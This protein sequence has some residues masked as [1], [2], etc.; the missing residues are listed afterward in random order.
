MRAEAKTRTEMAPRA[1]KA[2][3]FGRGS[4]N[5]LWTKLVASETAIWAGGVFSGAFIY[6]WLWVDCR[7]QHN[8]VSPVFLK[9]WTF[10]TERL[11]HPG[12]PVDYVSGWLW[13]GYRFP[14]IGSLTTA[15][16]T[17]LIF[18]AANRLISTCGWR[19]SRPLA[20]GA[21][22][23]FIDAQNL[24]YTDWLTTALALG[25]SLFLAAAYSFL[26]V[27]PLGRCLGFVLAFT[28]LYLSA[29]GSALLFA[30]LCAL[31]EL[32]RNRSFVLC[33]FY[34]A[35]ALVVPWLAW[36]FLYVL[37][38]R[39][40]MLYLLPFWGTP[41]AAWGLKATVPYVGLLIIL[42]PLRK[43]LATSVGESKP[44]LRFGHALLSFAVGGAVLLWRADPQGK[45][46]AQVDYLGSTRAWGSVLEVGRELRRADS[47][48]VHD[49]NRALAHSGQLLDRMFEYPQSAGLEFWFKPGKT[50][51]LDRLNKAS[52]LLLEL[53]QVN[54]AERVAG[55]A[56]ELNGY[57]PETLQQL[58][59][60]N[61]LKDQPGTGLPFLNL[62]E[63]TFPGRDSAALCREQ[64]R[65]DP[66]LASDPEVSGFRR[67][68]VRQDYIGS[69]PDDLLMQICLRQVPGNRMALQYLMAYYLL[70]SQPGKV[71]QN[72]GLLRSAGFTRLPRHI[73][74]AV[75]QYKD[76]SPATEIPLSGWAVDPDVIEEHSRFRASFPGRQNMV[77]PASEFGRTYWYYFR[78]GHSGSVAKSPATS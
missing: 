59:L 71:V 13:Q 41:T 61:V 42:S 18:L 14:V 74:E 24:Y 62:W 53:G 37:T 54:Q 38:F 10:L 4:L 76:E 56:M 8:A 6:A 23:L 66:K 49:I 78:T 70:N 46:I 20:L 45:L 47:T 55:E 7:L 15:L 29:G 35:V 75:L 36:R 60:I 9:S 44:A 28:L 68:M 63:K 26:R 2:V 40:A 64:L 5:Q 30:G 69:I 3:C 12:G 72:L 77:G 1:P 34:A 57:Q 21:T 39:D 50:V 58:L 17:T 73:Q 27:S 11:A 67:L 25:A 52:Q 51:R 43:L 22:L 65:L 16:L 32:S 48:A 19:W 33:A 31:F